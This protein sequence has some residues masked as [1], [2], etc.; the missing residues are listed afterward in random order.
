MGDFMIAL[1]LIEQPFLEDDNKENIALEMALSR[2]R[3]LSAHEIGHTLGFA[4]KLHC[5]L[6]F[7]KFSH[8]LS[9]PNIRFKNG[10]ISISGAYEN[11][12]G[13][14][15]KVS[16]A[17]SYSHFPKNINEKNA[18]D[19][20]LTKSALD[21]HRLE[22]IKMRDLLVVHIHLHIY[23]II[24][25]I[26]TQELTRLLDIRK[27]A[28]ENFSINHLRDGEIYST[29]EDR[30]VP[31]YL[32]HR[33]QMEA[34]VKLIG[35]VD[36][37]YAKG[38]QKYRVKVVNGTIQRNAFFAYQKSLSPESL[39]VPENSMILF[40]HVLLNPRTRENFLSDTGITFDY[41]GIANRTS[42]NF[43]KMLLNPERAN[44]LVT[45]YGFDSNQL[46][47][48]EIL[49]NLIKFHFKAKYRNKHFQQLNDISEK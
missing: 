19:S 41:L 35:G 36:Y 29:L 47:L 11:G 2:I 31:I 42:E 13:E 44:R 15:D 7:K 45:Q 14:W 33:Y 22:L 12:I 26:P 17:Y 27:K 40:H 5:K 23:G 28:L 3:Q 21:G 16:V 9:H 39:A 8:G 6:Q 48:E 4:H 25:N 10:A 37:D 43:I 30:M 46:S 20:I 38:S 32:L 34:V 24:G 1:G 49:D 18:L